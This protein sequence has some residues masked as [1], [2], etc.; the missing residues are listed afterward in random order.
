MKHA[1]VRERNKRMLALRQS[2]LKL[3]EISELTN[4][5]INT[6][7]WGIRQAEKYGSY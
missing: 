2:G 5:P 6:V 3:R 4:T 7:L 1:E